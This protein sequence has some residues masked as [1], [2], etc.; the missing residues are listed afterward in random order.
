V[1]LGG[2]GGRREFLWKTYEIRHL[3][4]FVWIVYPIDQGRRLRE[5]DLVI[6]ED[7]RADDI[8]RAL[9]DLLHEYAAPDRKIMLTE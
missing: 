2:R 6:P 9:E 1:L 7:A 8:P 4:P 5:D 3:R